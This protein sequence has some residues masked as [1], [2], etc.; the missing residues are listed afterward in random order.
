VAA[1]RRPL[2]TPTWLMPLL[3]RGLYPV[4]SLAVAALLLA[5]LQLF[6]GRHLA[7]QHL[8]QQGAEVAANLLLGELALERFS[9]E[10]L[11]AMSG[12][13]LAVGSRPATAC[14]W[15]Q[16]DRC[17]RPER[18]Q[19]LRPQARQLQQLLCLRLGR[20]PPLLPDAG[21]GRGV[22]MELNSPLERVWLFVP[23]PHPGG[24]PPDPWLLLIALL[25]G[26]LAGGLLHQLIE[27]NGPLRRLQGALARMGEPQELQPA[28]PLRGSPAVRRLSRH[29]QALQERLVRSERERRTMLAGIAHDL[30]APLTRLRLR[31]QGSATADDGGAVSIDLDALE[32]IT[33]QFL[34]FAG[35]DSQEPA[36]WLPLQELLAETA[37]V[38]GDLPLELD[39]VPLQRC[40][41]P[42]ALTRALRNLLDNAIAY[43]QPPLRV[44]LRPGAP[45][46]REGFRIEIWDRGA[47]IAAAD[48]QRA[49]MP[50]VRLDGARGGR[51]HTG[52]GLAIAARIARDHGGDL[53][54][55]EGSAGFGVGLS[56]HSLA[57]APEA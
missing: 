29:V 28:L 3:R 49:L 40:V 20:C 7:R 8:Q 10:S 17:D 12:M 54:R 27:V 56:G 15:Q 34:Q 47:G 5:L 24:W 11:A 38:V 44:V 57:P 6:L 51:G 31:L 53:L 33:T 25:T 36:V 48:W 30:R 39:L 4:A 52:L 55:L 21:A 41:R 22:W 1:E 13:R 14:S 45:G 32:R 46:E 37:A 9:P 43:G 16:P 18:V 50:F 19:S 2:R 35:A 42:T 23:L 26:G